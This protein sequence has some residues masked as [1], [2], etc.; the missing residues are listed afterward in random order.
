MSWGVPTA[1]AE[2]VL[3]F[4]AGGDLSVRDMR[5]TERLFRDRD[6]Q[7]FFALLPTLSE[8]QCLWLRES[9]GKIRPE[10]PWLVHLDS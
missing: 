9:L 10:H 6:E 4:K 7:D 1:A 3:F 5:T 2:V 8:G